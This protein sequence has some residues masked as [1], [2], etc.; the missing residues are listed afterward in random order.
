MQKVIM[1]SFIAGRHNQFMAACL[2][3][4]GV[5]L[6]P[7]PAFA[8]GKSETETKQPISKGS[9]EIQSDLPRELST[10]IGDG[11]EI[12]LQ[13]AKAKPNKNGLKHGRHFRNEKPNKK[14]VISSFG[15]LR[16]TLWDIRLITDRPL[17]TEGTSEV[18]QKSWQELGEQ[19]RSSQQETQELGRTLDSRA[20]IDWS[21]VRKQANDI[22]DELMRL[23]DPR[24]IVIEK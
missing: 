23:D 14:E 7:L 4:G 22:T 16:A 20:G 13:A 12:F 2:L 1:P 18:A 15:E 6:T 10:A 21:K 24:N 17:A 5:A 11:M 9:F 19:I 8:D 3:V